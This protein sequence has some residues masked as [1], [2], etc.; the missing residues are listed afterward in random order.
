MTDKDASRNKKNNSNP[1][2]TARLRVKHAPTSLGT[3]QL[4]WIQESKGT[5]TYMKCY[6][7]KEKSKIGH[8]FRNHIEE[9]TAVSYSNQLYKPFVKEIQ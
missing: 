7:R 8:Y 9:M 3:A 4:C 2:G 1:A 5:T 6:Q